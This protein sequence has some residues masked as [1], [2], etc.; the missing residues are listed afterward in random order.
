MSAQLRGFNKNRKG[1]SQG[2]QNANK[3]RKLSTSKLKGLTCPGC[4]D[5]FP[6]LT[7]KALIIEHHMMHEEEC[8]KHIIHCPN[9][10]CLSLIHI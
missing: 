7:T 9:K 6:N 3:R 8:K 5:Y 4:K 2:D 10:L 1:S